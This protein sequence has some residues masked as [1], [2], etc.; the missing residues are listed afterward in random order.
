M[1]TCALIVL[2]Y[3]GCHLLERCLPSV[4]RA[5]AA[6]GPGHEVVV[7]DNGSTDGSL[8]WVRHHWPQVTCVR[9][10]ANRFLVSYNEYLVCCP[11]RLVMLLNNDVALAPDC[12]PPLLR[13]FADPTVFAVAPLV[14]NE[15]GHTVETGRTR[16]RFA[17]GRFR[18]YR[19]DIVPGLT[20]TASTSAG[21]FDRE[22][23]L[24]V[25]GF[26]ELLLP[27]YGEEMD[28]T[29]SAYR[30]GWVV[31]YEPAAVAHHLGGAS[32][33]IVTTRNRRR[34][35]LVKNRHLSMIKHV[36]SRWRLLVYAGWLLALLPVRLLTGDRAFFV[37]SWMAWQQRRPALR[38][39]RAEQRAAVL[40]DADLFRMLAALPSDRETHEQSQ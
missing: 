36:H 40:A 11:H 25:G 33:N 13:H 19:V 10:A 14:W 31:R 34:V 20:A 16:L 38:Q 18:Y 12:L 4:V 2:N 15:P 24:A 29:L 21:M 3:N 22:K 35:S 26:D 5:A 27:M 37:G 6:A 17:Q 28:L 32:I 7:L 9:A 39:R 1:M 30:R 23:L 8:D